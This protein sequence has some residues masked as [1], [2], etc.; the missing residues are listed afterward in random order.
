VINP[1]SGEVAFWRSA[2]F[3]ESIVAARQQ[4]GAATSVSERTEII[5]ACTVA[6]WLTPVMTLRR[7]EARERFSFPRGQNWDRAMLC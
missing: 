7:L 2:A 1:L 5:L 3:S 4:L 6:V